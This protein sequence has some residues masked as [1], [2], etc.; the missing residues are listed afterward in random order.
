MQITHANVL[1]L[2][3]AEKPIFGITSKDRILQGY[4]TIFDLSVEKIWHAFAHGARLI[5]G[6]K[7]IMLSGPDFPKYMRKYGVTWVCT[8]PSL[9]STIEGPLDTLRMISTGGEPCSKELVNRW[10][11]PGKRRFLNLYGTWYA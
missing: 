11:L 2:V 5:V 9:L 3:W 7:T 6:T 1:N 4:T 8:T 10:S